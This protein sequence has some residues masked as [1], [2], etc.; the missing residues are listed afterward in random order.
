MLNLVAPANTLHTQCSLQLGEWEGAGRHKEWC[1]MNWS[2]ASGN[3]EEPVVPNADEATQEKQETGEAASAHR[4]I[5]PAAK[6]GA[7]RRS[8]DT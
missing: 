4:Q 6:K 3:H 5:T 1:W 2:A 7:R 8:G